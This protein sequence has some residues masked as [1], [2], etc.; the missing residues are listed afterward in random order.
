MQSVNDENKQA[1]N[2]RSVLHSVVQLG[3]VIKPDVGGDLV[4][5]FV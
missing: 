1:I 4:A 3:E 5:V 2:T